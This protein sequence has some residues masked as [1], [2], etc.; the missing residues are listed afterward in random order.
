MVANESAEPAGSPQVLSDRDIPAAAGGHSRRGNQIAL[1]V[2][3][4]LV[5][6]VAFS[7][8]QP[9]WLPLVLGA[10]FA[11]L[12]GPFSRW[13]ANLLAGKARAAS[14]V[15]VLLV[16]LV[17]SPLAVTL[18]TLASDAT[19]LVEDVLQSESA[20]SALKTLTTSGDGSVDPE[21][22][23]RTDP[24]RLL[25]LVQQGGF[26]A[27]SFAS[28]VAG[29]TVSA[30]VA[31]VV[32]VTSF[33]AFLT[34]GPELG[35]W[36]ERNLPLTR[37]QQHGYSAAFFETGRGLIVGLGMTAL[38]QGAIVGVSYV[39]VGLPHAFVLA[40]LTALA[41]LIPSLGTGLVWLPVAIVLALV[42]RPTD[43]LVVL[44]VGAV[45][46]IL[47]NFIRPVLSRFGRLRVPTSVLFC[48]MLGG[49]MAFGPSGLVIGPLFVRLA[50]EGL[51]LWRQRHAR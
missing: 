39:I 9:L 50:M 36:L 35:A 51:R 5:V 34:S 43:A 31:L 40:F 47:D 30:I 19:A 44:V 18:L 7:S 48:A 13:L 4:A 3:A 45:A 14:V 28:S 42:D 32:F 25:G 12:A 21:S 6:A 22:L 37:R 49:V 16:L 8:L 11:N 17:V 46:G 26:G 2:S 20:E 1:G 15:S 10:W 24:E 33:Y 38:I 41:G 23:L 27:F 29:A